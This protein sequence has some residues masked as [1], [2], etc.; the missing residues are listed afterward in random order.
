MNVDRVAAQLER[1]GVRAEVRAVADSGW[2]LDNEPFAPLECVDAHS[3]PPVEAIRRGQELWRGRIPDACGEQYPR[4]PWYCYFG[5]RLYETMKCESDR[6]CRARKWGESANE[7][8]LC[9]LAG[10]SCFRPRMT[11]CRY[12]RNEER[13]RCED[14][15]ILSSFEE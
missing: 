3:C 4:H 15:L 8:A 5:Y 7:E 12:P 1:Q 10:F 2:F 13:I 11:K 14:P 6:R 9:V